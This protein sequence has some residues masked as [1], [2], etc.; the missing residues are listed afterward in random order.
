MYLDKSLFVAIGAHITWKWTQGALLGIP[1]SGAEEGGYFRTVIHEGNPLFTGGK[2]GA[3]AT[4]SAT[5]ILTLLT[6]GILFYLS[7]TKK[8]NNFV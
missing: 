8:L 7:K 4:L 1:V 2:F 3:E 5:V 6:L